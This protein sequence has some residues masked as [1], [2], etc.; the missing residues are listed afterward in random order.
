MNNSTHENIFLRQLY[1]N[2]LLNVS[3]NIGIK[4]M[5]KEPQFYC[6]IH[7]QNDPKE[8]IEIYNFLM[9]ALEFIKN[10]IGNSKYDL[11]KTLDGKYYFIL[12]YSRENLEDY[13]HLSV[14]NVAIGCFSN[15]AY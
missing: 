6:T 9:R 2:N 8:D 7:F 10:K 13:Y 14:V 5:I 12:C 15:I 11:I 3:Q 4:L 1:S